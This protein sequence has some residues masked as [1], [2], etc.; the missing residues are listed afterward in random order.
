MLEYTLIVLRIMPRIPYQINA[1]RA[2][3]ILHYLP[4]NEQGHRKAQ[5]ISILYEHILTIPEHV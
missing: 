3:P 2:A 4:E 1:Y 5:N